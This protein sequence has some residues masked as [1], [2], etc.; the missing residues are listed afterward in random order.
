MLKITNLEKKYRDFH[1]N[2]SL[3]VPAGRVTGLIGANGAGKSTLIKAMLGLISTDNGEIKLFGKSMKEIKVA[4]KEKMGVVL[5]ESGFSGYL[6]IRDL[7]PILSAMYHSFE[8]EK[9]ESYCKQYDL[10]LDKKI[11]DF[12]TGMKAKLKVLVA[13]IHQAG[14][15]VLDEPTIG[16]DVLVRDELLDILRAYM[17]E[18]ED[19]SI[20]ISSHISSDLEGL[21][22]DLYMIDNGQIVLHEE[23]DTILDGYGILK[24]TEEQY[25]KL[26]Q[27]YILRVRQESFG[28]ACLTDQK[29]FYLENYPDL[30]IEKGSIDEVI[31]FMVRGEKR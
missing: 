28:Y 22:D 25:Q 16:L 24:V 18:D 3:E 13:I 2:C 8:K 27:K 19:R 23:V 1:L 20:L 11:K 21:C 26:E 29:Q 4:D 7:I 14:F 12:S 10:P 6:S 30:T 31:S 5:A 17:E 9:F 15:L